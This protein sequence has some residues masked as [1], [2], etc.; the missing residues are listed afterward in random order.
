MSS[1]SRLSPTQVVILGGGFGGISTAKELGR[2][3]KKDPPLDV[4]LVNNENY[5]VFQP[6]LPEVISC[7]IE[8]AHILCPFE[9]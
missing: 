2:F 1:S 7:G 5:F 8:P 9:F 3:R 6:L 4:H